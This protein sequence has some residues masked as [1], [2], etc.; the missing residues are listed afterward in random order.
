MPRLRFPDAS[1]GEDQAFIEAC[2]RRGIATFAADRFNFIQERNGENTW[3]P[4][5]DY[6][7]SS[8]TAMGEGRCGESV[9][10]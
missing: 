9:H 6:F 1:L 10:I 7:L 2:H 5:L 4:P 8:C 3:N